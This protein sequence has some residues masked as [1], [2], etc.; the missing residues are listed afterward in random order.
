[1]SNIE[2]RTKLL[3]EELFNMQSGYVMDLSS[4]YFSDLIYDVT[5]IN[6][7]DEK[8]NFRSGSKANRLSVNVK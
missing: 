5:H 8:Y 1:M 4:N 7:Y 2:V 6:I 3:L